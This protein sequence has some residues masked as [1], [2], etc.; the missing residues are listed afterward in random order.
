MLPRRS[1]KQ[2]ERILKTLLKAQ[3]I[4][5]LRLPQFLTNN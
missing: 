1:R 3:E 2:E 4:A 5:M